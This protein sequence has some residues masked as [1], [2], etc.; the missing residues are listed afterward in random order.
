M[1][2]MVKDLSAVQWCPR[3]E[4]MLEEILIRNAFD[5]KS[6]AKEFQRY[7]NSPNNPDQI[8]T[9][10]FKIESR[11][12]QLK[13]TDIEIRKHVIPNMQKERQEEEDEA[14]VEDDLPPLE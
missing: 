13:W 11:T 1:G 4:S 12:L 5:F 8:Q 3:L 14:N 6:T 2:R 10:F 9:L 7:L